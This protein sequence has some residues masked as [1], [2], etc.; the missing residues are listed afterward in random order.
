MTQQT[1]QTKIIT[2]IIMI[3]MLE[4]MAMKTILIMIMVN[5]ENKLYNKKIFI[6]FN[7]FKL[8]NNNGGNAENS[9]Y[10]DYDGGNENAPD[11][12]DSNMIKVSNIQKILN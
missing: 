5:F 6:Q 1:F 10:N 9:G 8:D 11:A 7:L 2:I 3:S 12:N 4:P